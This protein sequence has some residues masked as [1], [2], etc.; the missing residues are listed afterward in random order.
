MNEHMV[1]LMKSITDKEFSNII[2]IKKY[3]ELFDIIGFDTKYTSDKYISYSDYNLP[4]ENVMMV[5]AKNK[6]VAEK[7]NGRILAD[8]SNL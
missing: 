3:V 7:R 5:P 2:N 4:K 8:I 6:I 1:I